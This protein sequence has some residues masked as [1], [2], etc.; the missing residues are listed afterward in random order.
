VISSRSVETL[1]RFLKELPVF[2]APAG[3]PISK[4]IAPGLLFR[5]ISEHQLDN[6]HPNLLYKNTLAAK[7]ARGM[8][9][10]DSHMQFGKQWK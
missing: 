6:H 10:M 8:L 7:F 2:A 1:Q 5:V 4:T 3:I 9:I